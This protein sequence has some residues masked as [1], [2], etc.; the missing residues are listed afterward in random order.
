MADIFLVWCRSSHALLRCGVK[1]L[2]R[3]TA[4][5]ASFISRLSQR[6]GF[7]QGQS[8]SELM[9]LPHVRLSLASQHFIIRACIILYP[10]RARIAAA[11]ERT[12]P[13]VWPVEINHQVPFVLQCCI[14]CERDTLLNHIEVFTFHDV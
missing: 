2:C 8:L 9:D 6:R 11:A 4:W 10:L 12:N 13:L 7:T 3:V 14:C 5:P 1:H